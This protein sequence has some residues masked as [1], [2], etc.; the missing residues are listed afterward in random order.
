MKKRINKS[1]KLKCT[2]ERTKY[3]RYGKQR[4]SKI[5]INGIL[6]EGNKNNGTEKKIFKGII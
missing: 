3:N 4:G 2:I 1:N 6:E 5:S